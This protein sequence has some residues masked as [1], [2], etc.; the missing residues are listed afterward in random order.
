MSGHHYI[1]CD[2]GAES[3]RVMLGSLAGGNLSV[4]EIHIFPSGPTQ[5]CG[6]LRW[7]LLRMFDELKEGL[8][9]VS[10][11]GVSVSGLS[12]DSWGVDYV[13]FSADEPM[14][15]LPYHYRDSRTDGA[16][17]RA[18]A[19]VRAEE[20]FAET[21]IQFM[22]INTL[23]QLHHDLEHRAAVLNTADRFLNIGDYF[24]Y[25][26]CSVLKAD[27]SLASTTQLYNPHARK[28]S[29]TLIRKFGFPERIF[30]EVV[31]S[32]TVLG[33]L[34]PP[35]DVETAFRETKVIAGCS[36]D[37]GAAVAAAP[38]A[39][40]DWAYLSSGT[41]SLLGVENSSPIINAESRKYNFTNEIGYNGSIRFLR[42]ITGLWILQEC[43][44]AWAKAGQEYTYDQ[45]TRM[46]EKSTPLKTFFDP[47]D[48][49][50]AKPDNMPQ[51]VV[52]NCL[53]NGQPVPE[54]PAEITRCILESL[55]L[56]YRKT[57][58]Q[59]REL[60]R[61]PIST[62][63]IVGGGC[64][65]QLLNQFAADATGCAVLAG[66]VECTAIGNV[67]I[68]AITLGH[69]PSLQS[70]REIV[71]QSF[72]LVRYDPQQRARWENAYV[73]FKEFGRRS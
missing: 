73:K 9:K 60:T 48:S 33:P 49:I 68:Q 70:G 72:P 10:A 28:W 46:A 67:L 65:N 5:I 11:G 1:A 38:A 2:L 37:T 7:D 42:N 36:H 31:P 30:P 18:F 4:E 32:G 52:E 40:N 12:C 15:A 26:F 56:S 50:F 3:G 25:L 55:A 41:W 64:K 51:K 8:K 59:L 45:L 54:N 35:F 13:L 19:V 44:R 34:R 57:L 23:Y 47:Q 22:P 16:F 69:I 24:N 66:P 58:E 20:I 43:R 17:E 14:L 27:E 29:G 71:G 62:L 53:K 39:G 6:S 61:R 21:G 63:H